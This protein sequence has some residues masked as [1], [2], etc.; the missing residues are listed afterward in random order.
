ME[1]AAND[2]A[3]LTDPLRP[4]L[5]DTVCISCALIL[6]VPSVFQKLN[7]KDQTEIVVVNAPPSMVPSNSVARARLI[8]AHFSV[9]WATAAR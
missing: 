3:D 5:G 9:P 6:P 8:R 1:L 4:V 2:R 7:L